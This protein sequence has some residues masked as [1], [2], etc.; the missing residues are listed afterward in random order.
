MK[1]TTEQTKSLLGYIVSHKTDDI[2][3]D[4]CYERMAEFVEQDLV[5][6]EISTAMK[7]VERHVDQCP[8]CDDEHKAL[9]EA[10]QAIEL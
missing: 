4:G 8:C 7:Q 3:C 6:S 2:D 9:M 1:L 5:G 10:L